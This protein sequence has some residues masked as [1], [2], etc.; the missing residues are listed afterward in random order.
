MLV[1]GL[2]LVR[3]D[4]QPAAQPA[5]HPADL[6]PLGAEDPAV[7]GHPAGPAVR[8]VGG[9]QQPAVVQPGRGA[10]YV[11]DPELV[12]GPG[13]FGR[14]AGDG[15]GGQQQD[16]LLQPVGDGEQDLPVALP[17]GRGQ[18]RE[19]G[20][21]PVQ[22]YPVAVQPEHPQLDV[23]VGAAGLRVGEGLGGQLRVRRVGEVAQRQGGFVHP[24]GE[25]GA[26]VGGP[27]VAAGAAQLLGGG[28]L[29]HAP[30]GAVP[31]AERPAGVQRGGRGEVQGTLGDVGDALPGGVRPG[32]EGG[33]GGG[34]FGGGA[35]GGVG[36]EEPSVEGEDGGR[37]V[38]GGGEGADPRSPQP[39]PLAQP[40]FGRGQVGQGAGALGGERHR[41]GHHGLLAGRQVEQPESVDRVL[42]A[43][44][45]QEEQAGAVGGEGGGARRAV[46]EPAGAGAEGE[47]GVGVGHGHRCLPRE[48][49]LG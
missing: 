46:A 14:P 12:G 35:V 9:G 17:A 36:T 19:G 33:G 49:L 31:R 22:P 28:E 2:L 38:G 8:G 44:G 29:G 1:G 25:D 30:G 4:Q 40:P 32:V 42:R 27:P 26:A 5:H 13:E 37:E 41:V 15:V 48:P 45:A 7:Q 20:G 16:V 39:Q 43:G 24:G 21:V 3:L 18:V 34:Q 6:D 11:V 23:G 10:G 47:E